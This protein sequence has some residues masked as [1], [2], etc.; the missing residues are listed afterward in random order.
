MVAVLQQFDVCEN[1]GAGRARA[2]F[3]LNM[4]H[5]AAELLETRLAIP[6]VPASSRRKT[7]DRLDIPVR[8]GAEDYVAVTSQLRSLPISDF[9]TCAL[10]AREQRYPLIH[11]ID[12][13]V[14]G[15]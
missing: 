3:I 8:I 2:P 10:S 11:A 5:D 14:T 13:L 15:Y 4:Q 1:R 6:L 12:L 9:G 7:L